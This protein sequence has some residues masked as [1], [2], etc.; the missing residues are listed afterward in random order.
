[1]KEVRW[2][3]GGM[4]RASLFCVWLRRVSRRYLSEE[5]GRRSLP[6]PIFHRE[7]GLGLGWGRV[8]AS[9]GRLIASGLLRSLHL[10]HY[11]VEYYDSASL[12]ALNS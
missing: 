6:V 11:R 12:T 1:M 2:H 5:V 8:E 9:R 7:A 10:N 4:P 3:E